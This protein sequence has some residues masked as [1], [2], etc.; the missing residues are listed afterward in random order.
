MRQLW[1]LLALAALA[2]LAQANEV[3]KVEPATLP[4]GVALISVALSEPLKQSPSVFRV[5]YP[6]P[7]VVLDL[8]GVG[9][10]PERKTIRPEA[11][12]VRAIHLLRYAGG[13]RL[14]IELARPATCEA[15]MEGNNLV[16]TLRPTPSVPSRP[17]YFGAAPPGDGSSEANAASSASTSWS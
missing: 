2:A 8:A 9:G 17:R 5:L 15:A 16:I 6:A 3:R 10:A 1:T 13:T 14:V 4:G 7:R 12:L 11:G